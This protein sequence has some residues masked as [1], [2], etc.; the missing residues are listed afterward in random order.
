VRRIHEYEVIDGVN[1][2]TIEFVTAYRLLIHLLD[3]RTIVV[4]ATIRPECI[5][6]PA[7]EECA[8]LDVVEYEAGE[9]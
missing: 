9:M 1:V 3:G 6:K 2:A 7:R 4:D 8:V 5:D